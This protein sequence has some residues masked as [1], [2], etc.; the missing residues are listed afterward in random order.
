VPL[1]DDVFEPLELDALLVFPVD[2]VL[3][4]AGSVIDTEPSTDCVSCS[5]VDTVFV[6][7]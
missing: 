6:Y 4:A 2:D 7:V 3:L 5:V 1:P